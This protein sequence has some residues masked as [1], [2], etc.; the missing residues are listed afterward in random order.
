MSNKQQNILAPKTEFTEFGGPIGGLFVSVA[1]PFF[2]YLLFFFCNEQVGCSVLPTYPAAI[3][4][5]MVQGIRESIFDTTAFAIYFG[6]Y[7]FVVAC[8]AIL[9]GKWVKGSELRTGIRL[10]YKLNGECLASLLLC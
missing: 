6:W 3:W 5:Q 4:Q 9:P 1:T 10:D 8:W 2:S 7:A